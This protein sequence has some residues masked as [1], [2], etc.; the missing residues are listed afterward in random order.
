MTTYA[1][2]TYYI[3]TYFVS[4]PSSSTKAPGK[5]RYEFRGDQ[6]SQM[7]VILDFEILR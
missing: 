7:H 6:M 4:I 2:R 5:Q 1:I 3:F